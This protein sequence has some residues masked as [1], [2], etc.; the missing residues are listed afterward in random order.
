M[1]NNLGA[2]KLLIAICS[3]NIRLQY[4]VIKE[5]ANLIKYNV[6][7][8]KTIINNGYCFFYKR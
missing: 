2:E 7:N 6:Y 4:S 1:D 8:V 5:N 3:Y